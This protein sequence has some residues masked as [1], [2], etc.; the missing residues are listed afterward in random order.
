[1]QCLWFSCNAKSVENSF[2]VGHELSQQRRFLMQ[3]NFCFVKGS[4]HP[5]QEN[6]MHIISVSCAHFEISAT[7][8]PACTTVQWRWMEFCLCH[9]K[10]WKLTL[11][12]QHICPKTMSQLIRVIHILHYEQFSSGRFLWWKIVPVF[13]AGV[14]IQTF[15]SLALPLPDHRF[16]CRSYP[17][18]H[19]GEIARG[20][21]LNETKLH[22]EHCCY[23]GSLPSRPARSHSF[24]TWCQVAR[25]GL[26]DIKTQCRCIFHCAEVHYGAWLQCCSPEKCQFRFLLLFHNPALSSVIA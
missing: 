26:G 15:S 13:T 11:E 25:W 1:M 8:T 14:S 20:S 18:Q 22:V 21:V 24:Y 2:N 17:E 5:N 12:N 6:H 3:L 10:H 7:E 9:W 4:V 19:N 16:Q 23:T